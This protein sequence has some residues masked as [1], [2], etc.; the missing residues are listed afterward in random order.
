MG[1]TG[2]MRGAGRGETPVLEVQ[3]NRAVPDPVSSIPQRSRFS[4][5]ISICNAEVM[6]FSI[7][8]S[9]GTSANAWAR[10]ILF[11]PILAFRLQLVWLFVYH[12][13]S[14]GYGASACPAALLGTS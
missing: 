4:E 2:R 7:F 12:S 6:L 3:L 14:R 5:R 8:S 13:A 1:Q 9:D 11:R 10:L